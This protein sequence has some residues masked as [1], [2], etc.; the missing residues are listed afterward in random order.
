[1]CENLQNESVYLISK[2]D[3]KIEATINIDRQHTERGELYCHLL[4]CD[5]HVKIDLNQC[6]SGILRFL[7][8]SHLLY[9]I[10]VKESWKS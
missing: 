7:F 1:M 2:S 8:L 4:P 3:T 5:C 6:I 10:C 9:G